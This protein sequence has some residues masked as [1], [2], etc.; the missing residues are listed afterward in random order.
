MPYTR[1]IT[2]HTP[3]NI[4]PIQADIYP[5]KITWPDGTT[6]DPVKILIGL[7]RIWIYTLNG[8]DGTLEG[9]HPL[10]HL[11]GTLQNGYTA[12]INGQKM[13][14]KR[15]THCGCGNNKSWKPFPYRIAMTPIPRT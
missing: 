1:H 7:D 3:Q 10:D 5:A 12:T 15:S 9:E 11:T 13:I 4:T 14:I 8:K 2:P 6:N